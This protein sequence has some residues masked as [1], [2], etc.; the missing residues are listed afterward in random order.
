MKR[1]K[2]NKS[3]NLFLAIIFIIIASFLFLK[4]DARAATPCTFQDTNPATA[5]NNTC[6]C[7]LS[8]NNPAPTGNSCEVASVASAAA[9]QDMANQGTATSPT[10]SSCQFF[11]NGSFGPAL[12]SKFVDVSK[13]S[14]VFQHPA[15]ALVG[16]P[17]ASIMNPAN[18]VETAIIWILDAILSFMGM[19]VSLAATLFAWVIYPGNINA[20]YNN[21][22]IYSIWGTVR[23]FLNIAFILVLL[24]SAFS[25]VFQVEKY[26]YKKILLTLIIMALLVNFSFP[27]ARF[28]IDVSNVLMYTILNATF[29][30]MPSDPSGG[31][32][33]FSQFAGTGQFAAI[34]K[35]DNASITTLI[36]SIIFAF[37]L[38]VTFL[39][40][41]ILFAIRLVALAIIIIFSPI[42]FVGEIISFG[43][44]FA[45]KWW[46]YLFKYSFFAPIMVFMLYVA[47]K[48]L[49]AANQLGAVQMQNIANSQSV[50]GNYLGNMAFFAIPIIILWMGMGIASSFSIAGANAAQKW[51]TKG[52]KFASTAPGKAGRWGVKKGAKKIDR[53]YIGVRG[54][55]KAWKDRSAEVDTDKVGE[56]AALSRD[57]LGRIF[58]KGKRD[59][60]FYQKVENANKIAKYKKEQDLFSTTEE[61]ILGAMNK[62]DGKTDKESGQR[63][64]AFLQTLAGN[65]D[66]NEFAKSKTGEF[67]PYTAKEALYKRLKSSLNETETVDALHDLENI[68]LANGVYSMF[69]LT[70]VLTSADVAMD[71][72]RGSAGQR[73][74][75]TSAEQKAAAIAKMKQ[76]DYQK[77]V[78]NFH[79]DS[80]ITEDAKGNTTG[81]SD[82]GMDSLK[83]IESQGAK[84]ADRMRGENKAELLKAIQEHSKKDSGVFE[85]SIPKLVAELKK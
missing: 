60:K 24:F 2:K 56:Q 23:D 17:T 45:S 34:L 79:R 70:H 64:Q 49:A 58:D 63:T 84:Y 44:S 68:N 11:S 72:S 55:I 41:A 22:T 16:A 36:A 1:I 66:L 75:S 42:A 78:I 77:F 73:V 53:D 51:A 33:L 76:V 65:K 43:Q 57:F 82:I 81:L 37:L 74:K 46:N 26:S 5:K 38:G 9:C 50:N 62:L 7:T 52:M 31:S 80:A 39:T 32:Y 12:T 27:I 67:D 4:N 13:Q 54:A 59:P 15:S 10:Y 30:N 14:G 20:I 25:T 83:F 19:L 47:T 69:G 3:F 29:P 40:M 61:E 8:S 71:P 48:M 21:P 28:F 85:A 35:P 18:W 6:V